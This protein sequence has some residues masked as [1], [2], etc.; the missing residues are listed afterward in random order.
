MTEVEGDL[1]DFHRKGHWVV[2]TTNGFVRKNGSAVMGRGVAKQAA[3]RFP[4]IERGLGERIKATGNVV[5]PFVQPVRIFTFPVKHNWWE[6]ADLA[7]IDKSVWQL[8]YLVTE[9]QLDRVCL[10]RVGCGNGERTWEEVKSLLEPLDE[11]FT[12]VSLPAW[13]T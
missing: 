10:P 5:H 1:W 12:V 13:R 7:L 8:I 9:M 6:K 3:K 11:R 2:I 4:G